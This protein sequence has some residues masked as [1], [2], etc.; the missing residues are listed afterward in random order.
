MAVSLLDVSVATGASGPVLV[1]AG[2]ADVTSV[3]RLDEVLTAQI[4]R[5]LDVLRAGE[6]FCIRRRAA[7][8]P[9]D[10]SAG[11]SCTLGRSDRFLRLASFRAANADLRPGLMIL[12]PP[13]A[14]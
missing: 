6:M 14:R 1:L 12:N 10:T 13:A 9:S 2:E 4:A 7:R 5:I 8:D 11:G 3:T